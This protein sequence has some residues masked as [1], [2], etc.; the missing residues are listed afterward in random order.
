MKP[1]I[2][3]SAT[4]T[5]RISHPP[6]DDAEARFERLSAHQDM[7]VQRFLPEVSRDGEWSLV[8]FAGVFSHAV[9]K[10]PGTA[11][12]RVQEELGGRATALT[13]APELLRAAAVATGLI[14]GDWLYVRVDGVV[15]EGEFVLM[16]LE[17][18]EP[19]L[20]FLDDSMA[21]T[22]CAEAL[23]SRLKGTGAH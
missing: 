16:E 20:Y 6:L 15:V 8:F 22:R 3:A 23:F 10:R 14:P 17:C 11:D 7:L 4:N 19:R 2:S 5:F 13:P 9:L 12:F 18:L 1:A 21:A